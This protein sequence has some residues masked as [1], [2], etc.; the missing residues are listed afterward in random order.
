M[1]L[2]CINGLCCTLKLSD[3]EQKSF[4]AKRIP[5][6]VTFQQ[7]CIQTSSLQRWSMKLGNRQNHEQNQF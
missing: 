7:I 6:V 3:E 1:A 2:I 4:K 5:R